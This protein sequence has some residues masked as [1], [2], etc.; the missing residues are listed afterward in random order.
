MHALCNIPIPWRFGICLESS[1]VYWSKVLRALG[2]GRLG[3]EFQGCRVVAWL[4]LQ[5]L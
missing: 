5:G 1:Q 2:F 3:W 4:G